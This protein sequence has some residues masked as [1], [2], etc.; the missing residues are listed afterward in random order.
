MMQLYP[1]SAAES[2]EFNKI[3]GLLLQK[4]RTDGARERVENIRFHTRADH[5]ERE[6]LQTNEYKNILK[7]NDHFPNDFTRNLEKELKLLSVSGSVL[8]GDQLV[9]CL[10]LGYKYPRY[11]TV[12]QKA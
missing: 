1:A 5:M 7:A 8:A 9:A 11:T 3:C 6:L 10:Q 2:L 12:V 4:C